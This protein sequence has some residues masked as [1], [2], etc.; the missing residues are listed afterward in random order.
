VA[1]LASRTLPG[2]RIALHSAGT[3]KGKIFVVDFTDADG[4]PQAFTFGVD[5]A[6]QIRE[7]LD[8]AISVT[9]EA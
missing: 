1:T 3:S 9:E 2:G 7:F 8:P 5:V 6:K 4:K